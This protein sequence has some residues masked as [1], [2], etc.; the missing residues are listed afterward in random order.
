MTQ[1]VIGVL[2][3]YDTQLDSIWMLP[4][5]INA[6]VDHGAC[7]IILP[8]TDKKDVLEQIC[9]YC[10]G[11]LFTGG[12][13]VSPKLYNEQKADY[14]GECLDI[15]D[16]LSVTVYNHAI[17]KKKTILGIC[18]GLQ[19]INVM[20]GGT[21]YQDIVSQGKSEINHHQEKPYCT[22]S[23]NVTLV[24][25]S[26]L[27]DLFE[28]SNIKVNS[29]HHQSIKD[30][31]KDLMIN[32]ISQDGIIEAISSTTHPYMV[33]VQWHPEYDY[34]NNDKS[35]L[36]LKDFVMKTQILKNTI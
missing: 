33:A 15:L 2:P 19:F 29:I 20:Q 30:L 9:S 14:C 28:I 13:D 25:N 22:P 36:L 4:D 11:F 24:D 21:L 10:D 5:Y 23:H 1:T 26:Y 8:Y 16:N 34:K 32:G 17:L 18:R 3:L 35:S 12:Q 6:L 31:G 7:P 27:S